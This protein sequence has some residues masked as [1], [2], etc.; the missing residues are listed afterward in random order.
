MNKRHTNFDDLL[1]EVLERHRQGEK[2]DL[3]ALCEEYPELADDIRELLPSVL[4]M[5]D[6]KPDLTTGG[7][8]DAASTTAPRQIGEYR[9]VGEIARGGMGIVYEAEQQS[10]GRRVALK[11]LPHHIASSASSVERFQREARAAARMHHS[12]IVP[13]FEVGREGDTLF[14]TMQLIEGQSLDVVIQ[15]LSRLEDLGSG[16]A[17]G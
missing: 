8:H 4:L 2:P 3:E 9:I 15:D 12:N 1:D 11:V 7:S 17:P 6:V 5:E 10:L 16:K 14:Y 13:V